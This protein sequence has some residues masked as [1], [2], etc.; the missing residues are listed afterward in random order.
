M[1]RNRNK[2][3]NKNMYSLTVHILMSVKTCKDRC[4]GHMLSTSLYINIYSE[5][6]MIVGPL[7]PKG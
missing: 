1:S 4:L 5:V 3:I 2:S 6:Y 7:P